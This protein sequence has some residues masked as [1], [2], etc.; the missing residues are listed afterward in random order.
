M[1]QRRQ[2]VVAPAIR[3]LHAEGLLATGK[4]IPH[5]QREIAKISVVDVVVAGR[6]DKHIVRATVGRDAAH[7]QRAIAHVMHRRIKLEQPAPAAA[8][9]GAFFQG[10]I[11]EFDVA[12]ADPVVIQIG[13][14]H[15]HVRPVQAGDGA[16]AHPVGEVVVPGQALKPQPALDRAD[17]RRHH[18]GASEPVVVVKVP[19]VLRV[20]AVWGKAV[21]VD[22]HPAG[23]LQQQVGV[24]REQEVLFP[25]AADR[26][27]RRLRFRGRGR[28]GQDRRREGVVEHNQVVA[29]HPLP[30]RPVLVQGNRPQVGLGQRQLSLARAIVVAEVEP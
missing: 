20:E 29:L 21:V 7:V 5:S 1:R 18:L 26:G 24:R 28:V 9:D 23:P 13:S 8:A 30:R 3:A 15:P 12:I 4:L 17:A 10:A 14:H 25:G 6:V 2:F 19:R 16:G 27:Q 22:T 11:S